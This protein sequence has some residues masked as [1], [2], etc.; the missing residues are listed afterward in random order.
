MLLSTGAQ[1]KFIDDWDYRG[2]KI[3]RF[4]KNPERRAGL[5]VRD[6]YLE[7][8]YMFKKFFSEQLDPHG[9]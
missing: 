5:R 6:L 8:R 9:D 4:V 3:L 7:A 1:R 2:L